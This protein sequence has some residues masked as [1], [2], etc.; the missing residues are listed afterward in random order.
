MTRKWT[1]L[2]TTMFSVA[3]LAAGFSIADD[4]KESKLEGIMEKV[5]KTNNQITKAVR[6]AAA[7]KKANNGKDVVKLADELVK[8]AKEAK[9]IK[10][11]IK[12]AKDLKDPEA[13]WDSLMDEFIKSAEDLGQTAG[14]TGATQ[15]ETKKAHS[16][17]KAKCANC[18]NIFRIETDEDFDK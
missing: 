9:P 12:N 7:F 13:K 16:V 17:V 18:H 10:D 3:L 8:L 15:P 6:S 14:K 4:E 5:N 2:A 11:A 1:V